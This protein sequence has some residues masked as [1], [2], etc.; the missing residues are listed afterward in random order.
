MDDS[1]RLAP[2]AGRLRNP[3][4]TCPNDAGHPLRFLVGAGFE[5]SECR[6]PVAVVEDRPDKSNVEVR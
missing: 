2:V 4:L 3:H 6:V 1:E 5:C